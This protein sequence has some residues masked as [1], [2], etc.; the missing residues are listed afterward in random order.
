MSF[1][2]R[3]DNSVAS[4][5]WWEVDRWMLGLIA[6]LVM[7][8]L[9]LAFTASP[10]VA[11]RL[12]LDPNHFAMRQ[13]VFLVLSMVTVVGVSLMPP[14]LIKRLCI[15]GFPVLLLLLVLTLFTQDIKGARR[16]LQLGGLTLQ[17]SEFMK[18]V[19][20]VVTAWLLSADFQE[21]KIPAKWI[22][23]ALFAVLAVILLNQ[24]D[25]G[26]TVLLGSVWLGQMAL[27][28]LPLGYMVLLGSVGATG[29]LGAYLFLPHVAERINT[30][31]DPESGDTFQ[32]RKATEAF[33]NGGLLGRGPGEGT[34]KLTLPDAHTDFILAVVG[35]EFGAIAVVMLMILFAAIVLRGLMHMLDEDDPF[36]LLAAAGLLMQF[37]VQALIN[38]G[39]NLSILP[40]K[41]MTLPFVSYG[42]S[43]ML[44]L[45]GGMGMVLA[46]TRRNRFLKQGRHS[47]DVAGG[48]I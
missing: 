5:W 44:A 46:F 17:P 22:S 47:F 9:W 15:I 2:S 7:T 33:E 48:R 23:T 8:G 40:S 20:I 24:P 6:I 43:S 14:K 32:V 30:F 29:L 35:E 38:I 26:Q 1:F 12:G 37:G 28:G 4:R 31:I 36:R 45:A 25:V 42:G 10:A 39:V 19:F 13:L 11:M 21:D 27:A 18:P 34:E 16:W 3:A 41:G